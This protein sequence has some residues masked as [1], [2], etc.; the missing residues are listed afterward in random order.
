M[1]PA[2]TTPGM[3]A[4]GSELFVDESD[5]LLVVRIPEQRRFERQQPLGLH[6]EIGVAQVLKGLQQ[7]TAARQQHHRER[8]LRDDERVL[9][10]LAARACRA[11]SSVAQ[12]VVRSH[13]CAAERGHEAEGQGGGDRD[14]GRKQPAR[15]SR[16]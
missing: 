5:A 1:A 14:G 10:P 7:Q 3:R 4:N 16:G 6:P 2:L 11:A 13:S 15:A 12:S 9:E 8:G